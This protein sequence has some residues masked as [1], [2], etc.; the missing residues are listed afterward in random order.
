MESSLYMY[1][2]EKMALVYSK[3]S[4]AYIYFN[5]ASKIISI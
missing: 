4:L 3:H 1:T 2:E 5:V